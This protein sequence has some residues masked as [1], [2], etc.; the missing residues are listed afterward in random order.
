[1]SE[2]DHVS[3]LYSCCNLLRAW[4][5]E[6]L[7]RIR[8]HGTWKHINQILPRDRYQY[9]RLIGILPR[10]SIWHE[11]DISWHCRHAKDAPDL[12]FRT[13]RIPANLLERDYITFWLVPKAEDSS[14]WYSIQRLKLPL[15]NI[16]IMKMIMGNR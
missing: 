1:M 3:I 12:L 5:D 2:F 7:S 4:K 15:H 8:A 10:W 6:L 16:I 13:S 9:R 14:A 11:T